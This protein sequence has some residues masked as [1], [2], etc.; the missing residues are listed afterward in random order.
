MR[1]RILGAFLAVVHWGAGVTLALAGWLVGALGCDEVCYDDGD[2]SRTQDSWQWDAVQ[3]I[4][5]GLVLLVTCYAIAIFGRRTR[6][7]AALFA[8]Q[9]AATLTVLAFL[10]DSQHVTISPW[11]P[12]FVIAAEIVGALALL[13]S[14]KVSGP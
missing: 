10:V 12:V 5:L 2:W 7:A 13:G 11:V 1:Y 9:V 3:L 14:R 4:S 8:L 6:V